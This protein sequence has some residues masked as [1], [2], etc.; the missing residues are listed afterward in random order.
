M[1]DHRTH[2]VLGRLDR[3]FGQGVVESTGGMAGG[4]AAQGHERRADGTAKTGKQ[5]LH[6]FGKRQPATRASARTTGK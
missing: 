6:G 3:G 2:G 5:K 4:G 1:A